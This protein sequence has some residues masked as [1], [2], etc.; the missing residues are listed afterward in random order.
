[1]VK[2][3]KNEQWYVKN[4]LLKIEHHEINKPKFQRKKKWDILTKKENIPSEK[5]Y[6]NFLF[7]TQNSVH[8]ITFGYNDNKYFNID[9][10]NR[11]N[12]IAHFYN[13]PFELYPEYLDNINT[14][15]DTTYKNDSIALK[16][17]DIFKSLS[18]SNLMNFKYNKYFEDI[19]EV[20]LYNDYLKIKRDDF[21][22]YIEELEKKLKINNVD[23]FDTNVIINV[24][25]F[26][27]YSTDDLCKIFEDINKFNSSLTELELLASSL[28]SINDFII[29]DN[30]IK[31]SIH[32][33]LKKYYHDKAINESLVCYEHN[34]YDILNAYDFMI[35]FQNYMH[36]ECQII[37]PVTNDGLSLFFKIYKILYNGV[38]QKIT[39]DNINDF[40]LKMTSVIKI[41]KLIASNIFMDNLTNDKIFKACNNKIHILNK[42]NLYL[43]ILAIIGY[44][45]NKTPINDILISIEKCV[46]FHFLVKDISDKDSKKELKAYDSI[47][48]ESGGAYIDTMAEKIYNSP[49]FISDKI[50]KDIMINIIDILCKENIKNKLYSNATNDKRRPR[51]FFEKALIYYYYKCKVPTEFLN[52]SFW[53]EHIMPFCCHWNEEI[54]NDRLGNIIPIISTLNNKRNNKHISEYKIIDTLNFIDH[55]KN[56][57]PSNELYNTIIIHTNKKLQIINSKE[58]NIFCDNNETIYKNNFIKYLF[59]SNV[60]IKKN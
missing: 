9:G 43:I 40:I 32:E 22:P 30:I 60:I 29:K 10:N 6:I 25:L 49:T 59:T 1:M 37:S 18:Y 8:A 4:L 24:N 5:N 3:I 2:I 54:D 58:Y 36:I 33:T 26:E 16:I 31:A 23:R 38:H 41:L 39:S 42:N 51:K 11:I 44:N 15:I 12:A 27:G 28:Y 34:N 13:K 45:K 52:N 19:N 50:T 47:N 21:E 7:Q 48:Y 20:V 53:I 14:F 55:I 35:G 46:L 56:I 57:I 17:K